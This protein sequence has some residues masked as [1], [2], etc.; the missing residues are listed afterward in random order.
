MIIPPAFGQAFGDL[1]CLF[2]STF[3]DELFR[4]EVLVDDVDI[5]ENRKCQDT[6]NYDYGV[7]DKDGSARLRQRATEARPLGRRRERGPR[8]G[9]SE[10]DRRR[11]RAVG[12]WPGRPGPEGR[13]S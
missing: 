8:A 12:Q 6:K 4:F 9:D 3:A 13:R 10:H 5:T 2:G 7:R 11:Q 1:R